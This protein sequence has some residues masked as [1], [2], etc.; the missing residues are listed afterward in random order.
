MMEEADELMNQEN[1]KLRDIR[2]TQ[3]KAKTTT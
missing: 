2:N 3:C 1:I